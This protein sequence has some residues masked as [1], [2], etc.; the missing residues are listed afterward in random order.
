MTVNL[1]EVLRDIIQI[2]LAVQFRRLVMRD[3]FRSSKSFDR[4][5]LLYYKTSPFASSRLVD[6]SRHTNDR[7]ILSMAS[8]LHRQGLTVDVIDREAKPS[9]FM[10]LAEFDYDLIISNCA[11]NSAPH[12]QTL[13]TKF[14]YKAFVALAMG[15]DPAVSHEKNTS[16]HASFSKRTGVSPVVRRLVSGT[17]DEWDSRFSKASAIVV[18]ARPGTFSHQ[19]YLRYGIPIH[20]V[21]SAVSEAV[22]FEDSLGGGR[23]RLPTSFIFFGG[24]GLIC[25]GLDLVLE[26]FDGMHN[27]E[28][29]VFGPLGEKDF[30]KYYKPLLMVNPQIHVHGF[31]DVGGKIF[32]E[33]TSRAA[34]NIF[35]ASS[36][37]AATSV[38][39]AMRAGVIPLVTY[40]AG[41]NVEPFGFQIPKDQVNPE[42][43]R[44]LIGRLSSMGADEVRKRSKLAYLASLEFCE[45]NFTDKFDLAVREILSGK[46]EKT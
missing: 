33:V 19:S 2:R 1:V 18:N 35:P 5:A 13:L 14:S 46:S 16:R 31:V 28:L 40:E 32:Q 44:D 43:L 38:V 8:V 20:Y 6:K 11:G 39:T 26:A 15:P 45:S 4:R 17:K 42:A 12:H 30:W 36:E 10:Q 25:K 21:P 27:L 22:G 7:E 37:G 34:F 24:N 3:V 9:Q 41:V 29:H 23:K